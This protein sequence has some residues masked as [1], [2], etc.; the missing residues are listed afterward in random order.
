[1]ILFSKGG[2]DEKQDDGESY[3][4]KGHVLMSRGE[5]CGY[6]EGH[7][8]EEAKKVRNVYHRTKPLSSF[9]AFPLAFN[10][11]ITGRRASKNLRSERSPSTTR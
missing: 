10:P 5:C 2:N 7:E 8:D 6:D 3:E 9:F 4:V 11:T 1:M